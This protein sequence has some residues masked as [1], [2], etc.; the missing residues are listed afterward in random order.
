MKV[1]HG[2]VNIEL[3]DD[4][5]LMLKSALCV[6]AEICNDTVR[7]EQISSILVRAGLDTPREAGQL[8]EFADGLSDQ[9]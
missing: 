4:E 6:V 8:R 9:L 2:I 5:R 1:T 7:K 3:S